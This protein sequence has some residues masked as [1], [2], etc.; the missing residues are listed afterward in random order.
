MP[1]RPSPPEY[2]NTAVT[3]RAFYHLQEPFSIS[4]PN[5]RAKRGAI[6]IWRQKRNWLVVMTLL[7]IH[8]SG[9]LKISVIRKLCQNNK[10][11]FYFSQLSRLQ[12]I[13]EEGT[14]RNPNY[15]SSTTKLPVLLCVYLSTYLSIHPSPEQKV[16]YNRRWWMTEWKNSIFYINL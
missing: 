2:K 11:N 13:S 1:D 3:I 6:T 9:K 16:D 7:Q 15:K 5:S 4:E 14:I 12:P 10:R 8:C